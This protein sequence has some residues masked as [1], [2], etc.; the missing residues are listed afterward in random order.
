MKEAVDALSKDK[1]IAMLH[2]S[3]IN[4]FPLT[5]K[6]DYLKVLKNAKRAICIENN[7][8]GQFARLMRAE[9]GF[10]FKAKINK[11]DGRPFLLEN[12][13]GEIDAHIGRL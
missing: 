9:T 11:Y 8:T 1:N 4:P 10:E 3:E 13:I 2:F 5:D 7:A 12:L 6:F